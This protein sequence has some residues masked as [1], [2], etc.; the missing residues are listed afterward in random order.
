MNLRNAAK[1]TVIAGGIA[2][3]I[4]TPFIAKWEGLELKPYK[5][6]GG[7]WTVCY[8]ETKG[9]DIHKTYTKQEC[10]EILIKRVSEFNANIMEHVK[11]D[12]P[13]TLEA[14][15]TSFSYNVGESAFKKSTM[16]RKINRKDFK[17]ACKE[18][19]RWVYVGSMFVRGLSNR[20]K[21]EKKLCE[22]E[23]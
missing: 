19:D 21:A 12:I 6:V 20:R 18:L 11:V 15:I 2:T 8:G 14:S 10:E 22:A 3:M 17:G 7:V 23:L 4:S 13:Y 1:N 9:I 5:D 16:L